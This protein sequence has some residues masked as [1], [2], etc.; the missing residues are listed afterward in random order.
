[1]RPLFV[2][3]DVA[4]LCPGGRKAWELLLFM[5]AFKIWFGEIFAI[6]A[7]NRYLVCN[8]YNGKNVI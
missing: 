3:N 5:R 7:T 2:I 4:S 8:Q 6:I 1:M